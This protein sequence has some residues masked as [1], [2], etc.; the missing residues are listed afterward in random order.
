MNRNILYINPIFDGVEIIEYIDNFANRST[1][2]IPFLQ[3][4][5]NFPKE[6]TKIFEWKHFDEIWIV[7]GPWAFTQMRIITLSVNALKFSSPKTILKSTN[8]FDICRSTVDQLSIIEANAN[9]FLVKLLNWEEKFIKKSEIGEENYHWFISS[10][11]EK[12]KNFSNFLLNFDTIST[13][14]DTISPQDFVSPI[15]IKAP[16]ITW[17]KS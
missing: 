2:S 5:E 16:H 13:I 4:A 10:K 9:E 14:F 15:Y 6:I 3:F 1:I 12:P 11:S 17:Q 8:Y 7:S